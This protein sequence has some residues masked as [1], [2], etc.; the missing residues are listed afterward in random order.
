MVSYQ[1]KYLAALKALNQEIDKNEV[2]LHDIEVMECR[3]LPTF[4]QT[5]EEH[6]K[7]LK[8]FEAFMT[9]I[10]NYERKHFPFPG[11][12]LG[13]VLASVY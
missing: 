4:I 8:Q 13:D 12:D 9:L 5:D 6:E 1:G 7:A 10:E 2:L 3:L 11:E